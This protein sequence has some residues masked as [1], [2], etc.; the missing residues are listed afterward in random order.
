MMIN[1]IINTSWNK[2][3]NCRN[4]ASD[5]EMGNA[6]ILIFYLH[7]GCWSFGFFFFGF[8]F[9]LQMNYHIIQMECHN[10]QLRDCKR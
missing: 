7:N 8:L 1:V 4:E 3:N 10:I 9:I 6:I 5:T 2:G